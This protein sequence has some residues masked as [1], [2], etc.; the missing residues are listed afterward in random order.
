MASRTYKKMWTEV[1]RRH[2]GVPVF[3]NTVAPRCAECH[4]SMGLLGGHT[5][6]LCNKYFGWTNGLIAVMRLIVRE[7]TK[8]AGFRDQYQVQNLVPRLIARPASR[9][10]L[11]VSCSN[12]TASSPGEVW[13][14]RVITVPESYMLMTG[15]GTLTAASAV[16]KR[17]M[18]DLFILLAAISVEKSTWS[19]RLDEFFVLDSLQPFRKTICDNMQDHREKHSS[20]RI[21]QRMIDGSEDSPVSEAFCA[22]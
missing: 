3:D 6:Y 14:D 12:Q 8:S 10:A 19:S 20:F 15:W 9:G 7:V 5:A 16:E 18:R 1:L 2:M 4:R 11:V 17:K 13:S 21:N 22:I